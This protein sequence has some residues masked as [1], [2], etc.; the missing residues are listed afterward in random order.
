M[1][2]GDL[3]NTI[4]PLKAAFLRGTPID[5]VTRDH[6]IDN[7]SRCIRLLLD[8][9]AEHDSMNGGFSLHLAQIALDCGELVNQ[10]NQ[11]GANALYFACSI[12]AE[13]P[14]VDVAHLLN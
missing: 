1:N 7:R 11:Y 3:T 2:Y 13:G 12:Y 6:F 4:S 5:G 10:C 8:A 14:H 9:G